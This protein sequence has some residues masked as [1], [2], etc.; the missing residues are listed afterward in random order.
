[1]KKVFVVSE[2]IDPDQNSTGYFWSKIIQKLS[3]SDAID[4]LHVVAPYPS[5]EAYQY[6]KLYSDVEFLMFPH[7][8]YN[9]NSLGARIVG[10][11]KQTYSFSRILTRNLTKDTTVVSGTNPLLL[12]LLLAVLRLFIPFKWYLLVHDIFPENLVP[13][14]L[15]KKE[16][17]VF[18]LLNVIF[19]R[20][21]SRVDHLIV[22]G[23]DMKDLLEKRTGHQYITVIP[24]WVDFDEVE[25]IPKNESTIIKS[26]GWEDNIVFQF[27]GNIGRVQG[28]SN[29]LV[30]IDMVENPVAKFLFI[31]GGAEVETVK[32]FV[33]DNQNKD[34]VAYIGELCT[35]QRSLGLSSC[36]IAIVTLAE[37]MLGLGVPSKAYFSMAADKPILAIMSD[38]AEVASM[39]KEHLIGWVC[40][41]N[42]P[43]ALVKLINQ[44]CQDRLSEINSSPRSVLQEFYHQ[45]RLLQKFLDIVES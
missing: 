24:N 2:F 8:P 17:L 23:R 19:N 41:T 3:Q 27:F 1:M 33:A 9:K 11:F 21:Y 26:L 39:V 18:K 44:I 37:G 14:G 43:V 36:D 16:S 25:V 29:L 10:Q 45:D 28:I 6:Q 40:P 38:K 4:K 7:A 30:A 13:A 20:V 31:G 5:N 32:C 12:L 42:D 22:I 15:I 34:K 35:Q